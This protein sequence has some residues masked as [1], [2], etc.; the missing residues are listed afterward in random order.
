MLGPHTLDV[1]HASV[2]GCCAGGVCWNLVVNN[3]LFAVVP[4][5][6]MYAVKLGH[7]SEQWLQSVL[8]PASVPPCAAAFHASLRVLQ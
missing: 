6:S 7:P 8:L 1:A 3:G 2:E 4:A 5:E